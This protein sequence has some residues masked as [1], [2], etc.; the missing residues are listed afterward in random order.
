MTRRRITSARRLL[1]NAAICPLTL[2]PRLRTAPTN[3][4]PLSVTWL[5][6]KAFVLENFVDPHLPTPVI[7]GAGYGAV[8]EVRAVTV[9]YGRHGRFRKLPTSDAQKTRLALLV[10]EIAA[11]T[12]GVPAKAAPGPCQSR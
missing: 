11:A 2:S 10:T 3:L 6:Q 9:S 1:G 12:G 8:T 4:Q 7:F 5:H